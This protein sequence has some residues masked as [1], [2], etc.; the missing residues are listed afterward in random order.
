MNPAAEENEALAYAS[1][2]GYLELVKLLFTD[3]RVCVKESAINGASEN[4]H[5]D[6]LQLLI[7]NQ[8][9][10]MCFGT[11]LRRASENGHASIVEV[12]LK[13]EI[14]KREGNVAIVSAGKRGSVSVLRL[15][16]TDARFDPGAHDS[17]AIR[18]ASQNGHLEAVTYL[19]TI[20][21]ISPNASQNQ[22]IQKAYE[23]GYTDI[24]CKLFMDPRV[25]VSYMQTMFILC[26][27]NLASEI[28]SAR[29]QIDGPPICEYAIG[30][31][32]INNEETENGK[33]GGSSD[34]E[35][36]MSETANEARV[37]GE[38]LPEVFLLPTELLLHIVNFLIERSKRE[39]GISGET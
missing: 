5:L 20:P 19:L 13:E 10:A 35:T 32:N 23:N 33:E 24:V 6:I 8:K 16:I 15:L 25:N 9:E 22:A 2:G 29:T 31:R 17:G 37:L 39:L 38:E 14:P 27:K 34:S 18:G 12:L 1:Q 4:G 36:E 28:I 21:G 11:A 3:D 7:R 26:I 30:G